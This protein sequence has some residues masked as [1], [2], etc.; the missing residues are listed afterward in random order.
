MIRS[1]EMSG[2]NSPKILTLY[3]HIELCSLSMAPQTRMEYL[4]QEQKYFVAISCQSIFI[5]A[6]PYSMNMC[7]SNIRALPQP[8][9]MC[10]L[11]ISAL[12][13]PIN[14]YLINI[15]NHTPANEHVS[16][17]QS[18]LGED[19]GEQEG[20]EEDCFY[21]EPEV[22]TRYKILHGHPGGLT[23]H[24]YLQEE[25]ILDVIGYITVPYPC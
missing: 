5:R 18:S 16:L 20:L 23:Y 8:I 9:R 14:M 15:Q 10:I 4:Q 7:L 24:R 13:Q 12:P 21:Q 17:E 2:G 11:N 22:V 25:E 1:L 3:F 6:L 19:V